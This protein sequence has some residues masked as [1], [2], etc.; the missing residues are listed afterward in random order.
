MLRN[1]T[2][3]TDNKEL[4]ACR[5]CVFSSAAC[6][7]QTEINP[8]SGLYKPKQDCNYTFPIDLSPNEIKFDDKSI[9]KV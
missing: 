9:E 8:K 1:T 6:S 7:T 4:I 5:C 2:V 3:N